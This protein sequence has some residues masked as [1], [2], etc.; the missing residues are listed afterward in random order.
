MQLATANLFRA[1]WT[2]KIHD[3]WIT[4]LQSDR[5]DLDPSDLKRT[6]QLMNIAVPDCLV[7]GY[8]YLIPVLSLPDE[9]DRHVLSAAIHSRAD[10]I[11]TF[12]L[13]D[14]PEKTLGAHNL[15]AM[16]PD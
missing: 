3:E 5:P 8:E 1:K 2:D 16:H 15:E 12:N 11:V 9:N 10:A 7:T 6:R 4:N 14:F 13:K